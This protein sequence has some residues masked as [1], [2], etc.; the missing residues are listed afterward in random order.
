[1]KRR[2]MIKVSAATI[3]STALASI[4]PEVTWGC[5]P[6]SRIPSYLKGYENQ[7]RIDPRSAALKYFSEAKFGLFIHYGLYTLLEGYWQGKHSKPAE[8][9]QFRGKISLKE[10]ESLSDK[11]TAKKFDAD[12]ITDMALNAGMKYINFT[13]RHHDSFCLFDSE[14]TDFKSTNSPAKRDLV[15][16]LSEQCQQKGL[17]L[18]LYY[19]HGRDWRHPHAPN[20]D[21]WG[22]AARPKYNSI[23]ESYKYGEEHNLDIY[24]D[25]MKNQ[26][27]ELLTNYGPIAGIW[28]DGIG[29]PLSKPE[30]THLF[31]AQNLYDHI[32]S[33]QPQVLVSYKQG[34][35]G[36]EDFKA[37]E[38]HFKGSSE[39][40]LEICNTLQPYSWGYDKNDSAGHKSPDEVMNMLAHAKSM[41]ANLLLNTGPLP[42]GSIHKDDLATLREV[43]RRIRN[44]EYKVYQ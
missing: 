44:I 16:E 2:E 10:Y 4:L 13:T 37:P 15:R 12:F 24:L 5:K 39:V 34:L 7:Y 21:N 30:Q 19:S 33:L 35:L 28:L 32:H 14:Y 29:T 8:W 20:N 26:I 18:F 43:G 25:F 41:N 27:T 36:T 22:G 23:E 38:R 31:K 3:C 6:T 40:P 42:N 9:V 17:G 11:F 1:M